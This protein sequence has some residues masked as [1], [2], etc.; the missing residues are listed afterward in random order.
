MAGDRFQQPSSDQCI[1]DVLTTPDPAPETTGYPFSVIRSFRAPDPQASSM[2]PYT[3][4]SFTGVRSLPLTVH[5][6]CHPPA[7]STGRQLHHN[8][9]PHALPDVYNPS[10]QGG[11]P[12]AVPFN[13]TVHSN[14][15]QGF[16][17]TQETSS[18][19]SNPYVDQSYHQSY[20]HIPPDTQIFLP[21]ALT[22]ARSTSEPHT[23]SRAND[24]LCPEEYQMYSGGFSPSTSAQITTAAKL[25]TGRNRPVPCGW[26]DGHGHICGVDITRDCQD[27]FASAH[28]ITK[29]PARIKVTCRWC[30]SGKEMTRGCLLRHIREAHLRVGRLKRAR[31]Y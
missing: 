29:L 10:G 12:T 13:Q 24:V 11:C 27:H 8:A 3:A 22:Q 21:S 28:G 16:P 15:S 17:S 1:Q 14:L 31:T 25:S 7:Y 6:V 20:P 4:Q 30:D 19:D 18:S 5:S 2:M 23:P 26:K 9:G